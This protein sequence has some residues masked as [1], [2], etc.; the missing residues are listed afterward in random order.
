MPFQISMIV[1]GTQL[2]IVPVADGVPRYDIARQCGLDTAAVAGLAV[3]LPDK[4]CVRDEQRARQ[5]LH[6]QW[7]R[8]PASR[9]ASCSAESSSAGTSSYVD[10]LTCL[11]MAQWAR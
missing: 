8:F 5:Q 11:Q 3:G 6:K 2:A 9:R 7:S 4:S 1:L 10:L